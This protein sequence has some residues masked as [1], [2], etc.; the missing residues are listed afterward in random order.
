MRWWQ[1]EQEDEGEAAEVNQVQPVILAPQQL[2]STPLTPP[3]LQGHVPAEHLPPAQIPSFVMTPLPPLE[4]NTRPPPPPT[5]WCQQ[6]EVPRRLYHHRCIKQFT[7][8]CTSK[9]WKHQPSPY[10]RMEES[11][12]DAFIV[13]ALPHAPPHYQ[14][15][16]RLGPSLSLGHP[17]LSTLHQMGVEELAHS[18]THNCPLNLEWNSLSARISHSF[19]NSTL[20]EEDPTTLTRVI[21]EWIQKR[22][23]ALNT[24]SLPTLESVCQ[25]C[26]TAT[27]L[28]ATLLLLKTGLL[29]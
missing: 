13:S 7:T 29:T 25:L 4:P 22:A 19:L 3:V 16:D 1:E 18:L 10:K 11:Y 28:V 21:N 9:Q 27:Q 5:N 15:A 26:Q 20:R 23:I 6:L 12:T 17:H 2:Q 8:C 14:W 24:W